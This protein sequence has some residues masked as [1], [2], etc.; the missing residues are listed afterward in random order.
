MDIKFESTPTLFG[1]FHIIMLLIAIILLIAFIFLVRNKTIESK[2][3][4]IGWLGFGMIIAEIWKQ[5]FS[6]TYVY[7][8]EYNMW[9]FPWQLC[10]MAM[11]C[12]VLIPR[13]KEK[14]QNTLLVFLSTFSLLAAIMALAFPQDMLRPQIIF[15]MH[16]FA[17]HIVMLMESA[18]AIMILKKRSGYSFKPSVVLFLIMSVIAELINTFGHFVLSDR[19]PEP[20]MF[21][22]T[23]YY[24]STQVVFSSIANSLGII[25]E[26]LI[27]MLLI[28]AMSYV[29]FLIEN[30][31]FMKEKW[32]HYRS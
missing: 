12:S 17:Y 16:G 32:N 2:I 21:Q 25:P 19:K 18:L 1:T 3:K 31:M 22:I 6:R 23:L 8:E 15:T 26:I 4:I 11:Y 30:K 10:S 29:M 27:Y 24:P 14:N 7:P 20:N 5:W 28:I 13:L 9:F